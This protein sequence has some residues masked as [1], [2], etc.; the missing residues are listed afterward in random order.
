MRQA[1][2]DIANGKVGLA[3]IRG[4]GRL[5]ADPEVFPNHLCDIKVGNRLFCVNMRQAGRDIAKGREGLTLIR[6]RGWLESDLEYQEG[7]FK[8][9]RSLGTLSR[10][11]SYNLKKVFPNHLCDIKVGNRFFCVNMRQAGRDIANEKEGLALIRGKVGWNQTLRLDLR[12]NK[13]EFRFASLSHA[14]F[15]TSDFLTFVDI[16]CHKCA[17]IPLRVEGIF[18]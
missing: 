1:G 5:E 11:G 2:R 9:N 14:I 16:V 13:V 4:E 7:D 10:Y 8:R 6:G 12:K 18:V 17:V 15:R 3:L